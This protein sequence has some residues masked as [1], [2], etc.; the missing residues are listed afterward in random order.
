MKRANGDGR[1]PEHVA[2]PRR[3]LIRGMPRIEGIWVIGIGGQGLFSPVHL[4]ASSV[5]PLLTFLFA[6]VIPADC[7]IR[8]SDY[9]N[10][11]L[12]ETTLIKQI[13]NTTEL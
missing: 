3:S 7:R 13:T 8:S 12:N 5:H 1:D 6:F 11:R 9:R 2:L 10:L 4:Y